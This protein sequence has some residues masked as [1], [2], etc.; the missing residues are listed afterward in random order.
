M[1]IEHNAHVIA[2]Q[3]RTEAEGAQRKANKITR[4]HAMLLETKVKAN[5]SGRPGPRVI[6]G[7]YRRS[8][9][10]RRVLLGMGVAG[11]TVGTNKPQG[12][13]LEFGFYGADS[14]GRVYHQKPYP[15]LGPAVDTVKP[16]Y[17]AAIAQIPSLGGDD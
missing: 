1:N 6:T 16:L 5:A 2:F 17:H 11:Q 10:T 4:H 13:R 15:H 14:L 12:R 3:M 8:W 9:T 7:D